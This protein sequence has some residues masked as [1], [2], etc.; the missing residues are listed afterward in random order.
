MLFRAF[1]LYF[2]AIVP[3]TALTIE[4]EVRDLRPIAPL[5]L[6]LTL[7]G[8]IVDGDADRIRAVL[9]EHADPEM[10][11]ILV[12]FDSP[13]GSLVEGLEIARILRTRTEIV[14]AQ[15][16]TSERP[17]AECASACVIAYLGAD[18]RYLAQNGKIGVHQFADS[19]GTVEADV[20]IDL[21][22]RL[23]SEIVSLLDQQRVDVELFEQMSS[24]PPSQITWV[25]EDRLLRWR[26]VTGAVYDERMEYRNLNG[27]VALYMFHESLYGTNEMTLFCGDG[28]IAYAVLDEPELAM[29]GWFSFVIDGVDHRIADYE[30]LNRENARTRVFLKVPNRI[31]NQLLDARSLGAR[32]HTPGGNVFYGFEQTIRDERVREMTES[33]VPTGPSQAMQILPRTDFIG[34]DLTSTG[35]RG[36]SFNQCQAICLANDLCAAVSYVTDKQWCWPKTR[37]GE[38]VT[39]TG[40]ISAFR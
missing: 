12:L 4:A 25:S 3:A 30:L 19:S 33:C 21:A 20:G 28:L 9:A 5:G 39:A 16:G 7:T 13:G 22:Q 29:V 35:H 1:V 2:L 23:A 32:V 26:V 38:R 24:T 40:I 36:I 17:N 37:A 11:D 15:V 34:H 10:R 31:A 14:S 18:L 27:K 6:T 8:P